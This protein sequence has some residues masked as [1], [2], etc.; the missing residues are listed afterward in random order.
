MAGA[1]YTVPQCTGFLPVSSHSAGTGP[2]HFTAE[3]TVVRSAA[4]CALL[5]PQ[6]LVQRL[7]V[8]LSF[9]VF[10]TS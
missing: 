2:R 8:H 6:Q 9:T 4:A 10:V 5:C 1:G 7:S 3:S